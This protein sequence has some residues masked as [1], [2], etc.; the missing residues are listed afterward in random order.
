MWRSSL[1]CLEGD[2]QQS[3]RLLGEVE[4][5]AR[6]SRDANA[7]IYVDVLHEVLAFNQE[8]W[9]DCDLDIYASRMTGPAEPAWR[10]ALAWVLAGRGEHTAAREQIAWLTAGG[11]RVPDDMNRVGSLCELTQALVLVGEAHPASEIYDALAPYRTRAVVNARG[12]VGYGA[13]AHHLGQLAILI[14]RGAEAAE[15]LQL[16]IRQHKRWGARGWLARSQ[17]A[18]AQ[19]VAAGQGPDRAAALAAQAAD[20]AHELGL[21]D[22]AQ[23]AFAMRGAPA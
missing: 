18:Y 2:F 14:G 3:R 10:T 21:R 15:H 9:Q 7:R 20:T 6:Q 13:V 8:R 12:A 4:A 17:L 19:L 23:A 16:A 5:I 1:A 22:T 11:L